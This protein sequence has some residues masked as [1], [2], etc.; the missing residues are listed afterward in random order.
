MYSNPEETKSLK[1]PN[2]DHCL[3]PFLRNF[4]SNKSR[5]DCYMHI[6]GAGAGLGELSAE[7]GE[8]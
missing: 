3:N 1:A 8:A 4:A 7:I 6:F 2:P 5:G